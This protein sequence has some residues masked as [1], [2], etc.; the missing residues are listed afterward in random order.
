MIQEKNRMSRIKG[1]EGDNG[2]KIQVTLVLGQRVGW[3]ALWERKESFSK[4]ATNH[5]TVPNDPISKN[6]RKLCWRVV[7][8]KAFKTISMDVRLKNKSFSLQET[9][10]RK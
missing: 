3:K 8:K 10:L 9:S 7:E 2:A 5:K 4:D 6:I 1:E